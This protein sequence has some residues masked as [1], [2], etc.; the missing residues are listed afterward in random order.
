MPFRDRLED[1]VRKFLQLRPK[2]VVLVGFS[3]DG[4]YGLNGVLQRGKVTFE[5]EMNL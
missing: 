4:R 2:P 3:N 1:S 5:V